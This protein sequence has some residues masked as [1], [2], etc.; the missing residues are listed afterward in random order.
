MPEYLPSLNEVIDWWPRNF[1]FDYS[2]Y[3]IAAGFASLLLW[4]SMRW[5]KA[6]KIQKKHARFSDMR[7]EFFLSTVTAAI[8]AVNG[9]IVHFGTEAGLFKLTF[10]PLPSLW[11]G[12]LE[13]AAVTL[14]HDT[15]FYWA[16][17]AMHHP[18][19]YRVFHHAHHKSRTPTP[20]AAYAFAVPEAFV[21]AAVLPVYLLFFP[22]H[23]SVIFFFLLHMIVRNVIGHAGYE[24]FPRGWLNSRWT[25]WINT[26]THHD[27][28]HATFN[29]NYG[30]YFRWWDK[31]MG[32]EHPHYQARFDSVTAKGRDMTALAPGE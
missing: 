14:F 25:A 6:R 26:T 5:V 9:T 1:I 29:Y 27:L 20:W 7:R 10:E 17:R 24:L 13:F 15:Y 3:L 19:L 11:L 8:F 28:H 31:W 23:V 2:R 12:V 32:T 4:L 21:E 30:L 18:K 16:H 22:M